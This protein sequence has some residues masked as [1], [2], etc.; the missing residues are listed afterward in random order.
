MV[1]ELFIFDDLK[2][3][4]IFDRYIVFPCAIRYGDKEDY[5]VTGVTNPDEL[6]KFLSGLYG[7]ET[8]N[9]YLEEAV[10]DYVDTIDLFTQPSS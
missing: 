6:L 9:I 3:E 10:D 8:Y 4:V 1:Y 7:T 5:K 2:K